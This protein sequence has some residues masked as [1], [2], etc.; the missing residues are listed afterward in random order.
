MLMLQQQ[1]SIRSNEEYETVEP[2]QTGIH[3]AN[4]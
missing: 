2:I 1:H 4:K 3:F